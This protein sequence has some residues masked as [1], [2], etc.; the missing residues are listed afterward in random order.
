MSK[1]SSKNYSVEP[2]AIKSFPSNATIDLKDNSSFI[3]SV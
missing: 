3:P 1:T 2:M